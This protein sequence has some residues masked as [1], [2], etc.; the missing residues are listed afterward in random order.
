MIKHKS[1]V[2]VVITIIISEI[3]DSNMLKSHQYT[4]TTMA[5][6]V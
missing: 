6:L 2:P 3:L 4:V 5:I 1:S